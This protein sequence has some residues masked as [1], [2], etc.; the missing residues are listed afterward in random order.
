MVGEIG[1]RVLKGPDPKEAASTV[2][3][4]AISEMTTTNATDTFINI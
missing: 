1:R 4:A 3:S 2:E